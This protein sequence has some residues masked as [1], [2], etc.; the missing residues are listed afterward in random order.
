MIARIVE[1]E[2]VL[3]DVTLHL[4]GEEAQ[5][6]KLALNMTK[7]DH[8]PTQYKNMLG[9]FRYLTWQALDKVGVR[10]YGGK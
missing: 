9:E 5:K 4:T 10:M 1:K 8:D 2:P 7:N 6:L 3:E